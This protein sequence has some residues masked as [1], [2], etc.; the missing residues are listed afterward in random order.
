MRHPKYHTAEY[1]GWA[2]YETWAVALWIG[3]DEG[4]YGHWREV[5]AE[6]REEYGDDAEY[7]EGTYSDATVQLA[8][9][10]KDE[11]EEF[12]PLGGEASLYS[13][14]LNAALSNVNWREVAEA[15]LE[16]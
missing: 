15:Q 1:Q 7:G 6:L 2:N 4:S 14:L 5:A 13:D 11:Y 12:S 8:E 3:N 9:M 16:E 10:I